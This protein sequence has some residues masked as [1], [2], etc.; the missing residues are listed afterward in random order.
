MAS[1]G[2]T[3]VPLRICHGNSQLPRES[4][5]RRLIELVAH[6]VRAAPPVMILW[7]DATRPAAR[8]TR[9]ARQPGADSHRSC[10]NPGQLLIASHDPRERTKAAR[11]SCGETRLLSVASGSLN[12]PD[13][14]RELTEWWSLRV[15]EPHQPGGQRVWVTPA[16]DAAGR[17]SCSTQSMP[18]RR[19]GRAVL[20]TGT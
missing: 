19:R 6:Q 13:T 18:A 4:G 15:G 7:K 16:W 10:P 14:L 2:W 11:R 9:H 12:C 17:I 3:P 8:L 1:G 20:T 5:R